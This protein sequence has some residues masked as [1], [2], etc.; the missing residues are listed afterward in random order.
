LWNRNNIIILITKS[1]K[2][3]GVEI[4]EQAIE[5]ARLNA[6]EN[7]IDNAEFIIGK[8]EVAIPGLID[9]GIEAD[10]VVVDPPR[11]GCERVLLDAIAR[12]KPNRIVYVSCNPST[13]ARDLK[14]LEELGYLVREVQPVDMFCQTAHVESVV[15]LTR[16]EK[17][18]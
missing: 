12:M 14:I 13:L 1:K 3:Y 11:K 15:L 18:T 16:S 10:V 4:V 7:G 6:A 2:V 17:M 5:N 8:S 9:D